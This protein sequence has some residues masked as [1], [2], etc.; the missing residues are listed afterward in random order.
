[1]GG[2][3]VIDDV[4]L[5]G[6]GPYRFLLD[7]GAQTNQVETSLARKLG[8]T[9]TFRLE[10]DT[11]AGTIPVP[12]G[13]I[14]EVSLGS[15]I[16]SNQEFLFTTLDGVHNLSPDIRGVLGEEFL[17]HFDYLLDFA[18]HRLV[19]GAA[20]PQGGSRVNFATVNGCPAIETSEGKL[21]LD[22]GSDTTLLFRAS[23]SAPGGQ[24]RT[25]SGS[26]SVSTIQNLRLRIAGREYHPSNAASV[27]GASQGGEDGLVPASLFHG[28]LIRNS[29]HYVILM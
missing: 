8:L 15:A 5:N 27:P 21:V 28:I 13:H 3:P 14:A 16:A 19:F 17:A 22:S 4:F 2:R 1:M 20:D 26:A 25:A 23:S 7:T 10:M 18:G 24:I 9:P 6:Q 29:G 11:A 12:G